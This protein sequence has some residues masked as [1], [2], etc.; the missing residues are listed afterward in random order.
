M[1]EPPWIPI[2][3]FQ[4]VVSLRKSPLQPT[5]RSIIQRLSSR[6]SWRAA[7][8]RWPGEGMPRTDTSRSVARAVQQLS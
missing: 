4:R 8:C 6:P 2:N 5:V 3:W 1:K 7:S